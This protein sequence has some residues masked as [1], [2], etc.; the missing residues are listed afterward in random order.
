MAKAGPKTS[1]SDEIWLSEAAALLA[2]HLG[3]SAKLAHQ[4]LVNGLRAGRVPWSHMRSDGTRVD[5]NAAFWQDHGDGASRLDVDWPDNS[6]RHCLI[7]VFPGINL[8]D[9]PAAVHAIKVSRKAVLALLP[10]VPLSP[11]VRRRSGPQID[12]YARL[13]RRSIRPTARCP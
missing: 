2:E 5:G 3:G 8:P 10:S 6:A 4:L 9:L 13:C 11:P 7:M 1:T 12:R